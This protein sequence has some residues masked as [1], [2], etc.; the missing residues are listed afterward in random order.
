MTGFQFQKFIKW[1]QKRGYSLIGPV[2]SEGQILIQEISDPKEIDLSGHLPFYSFKKYFIPPHEILF[3]YKNKRLFSKR[4]LLKQ[5]IIGMSTFDLKALHLYN[6]VF[7]KDPYY[8]TRMQNTLIIGQTKMPFPSSRVFKIWQEKY[9]ENVL[10]HLQFDI[11]LGQQRKNIQTK[12][13]IYTGSEEGQSVLEKFGYK[14]Y[15][16][17][18]FAGPIKEE[19]IEPRFLKIQMSLRGSGSLSKG[20]AISSFW[21]KLA[22][23]CIECGKCTIVCPTCFCFDINDRPNLKKDEGN[24]IRCWSSCFYNEFSRVAGGHKFLGTTQERIYN[25]YYHKFVRVFDEYGF[26]GCVGCG[27]CAMACPAEIEI[28]EVLKQLS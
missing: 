22:E 10:E 26:P 2:K 21:K 13:R 4:T 11:F 3:N 19:G 8:Q 5:A 18:Q 25:W 7:E 14:N 28:T 20:V 12:F 23:K 9:E 17:I 16:H 27:R 1:L 24:R 6:H 15:E